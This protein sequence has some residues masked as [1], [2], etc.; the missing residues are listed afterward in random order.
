MNERVSKHLLSHAHSQSVTHRHP[1]PQSISSHLKIEKRRSKQLQQH[2]K[3]NIYILIKKKNETINENSNRC[4]EMGT[5]V[6]SK[7]EKK[8]RD[9]SQ[10]KKK[11]QHTTNYM[12]ERRIKQKI[13]HVCYLFILFNLTCTYL[14]GLFPL[15]H[16]NSTRFSGICSFENCRTFYGQEWNVFALVFLL[17]NLYLVGV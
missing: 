15:V 12:E 3:D 14:S 2:K 11:M 5:K 9:L 6:L 10:L 4:F 1:P 13:M 17:D 16:N 7:M 8:L